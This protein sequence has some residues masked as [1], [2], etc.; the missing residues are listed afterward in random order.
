M[1]EPSLQ[2]LRAQ[3]ADRHDPV[4]FRY[5]EALERRMASQPP[6]VQRRL[7]QRLQ[8]ATAQYAQTASMTMVQAENAALSPSPVGL[9]LLIQELD[10]RRQPSGA[11]PASGPELHS[12]QRF[13]ETWSKV[14][15]ERQVAQALAQAPQNAGPL[16]SQRLMLRALRLMH[17]LS[18]DYL[19]RFLAHADAL[20]WLEGSVAR[21]PRTAAK[22]PRTPRRKA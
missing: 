2:A 11:A 7:Q 8:S 16:N 19:R 10:A 20:L 1:A 3:G 21:M 6:A 5:L 13:R 9:L 14:A 18:P 4:R 15:A 12:V 17:R 22:P